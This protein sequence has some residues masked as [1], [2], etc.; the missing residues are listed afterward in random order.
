MVDG[1]KYNY[2]LYRFAEVAGTIVNAT[3]ESIVRDHRQKLDRETKIDDWSDL[4]GLAP[5]DRRS[6]EM[7]LGNLNI[8]NEEVAVIF[9]LQGAY[10]DLE[11]AESLNFQF[12]RNITSKFDSNACCISI[13][14]EDK[15]S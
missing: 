7:Y 2:L 4:V 14:K 10:D 1:L 11:T 5:K 13:I 8:G 6:S 3:L 9:G 15:V 12:L